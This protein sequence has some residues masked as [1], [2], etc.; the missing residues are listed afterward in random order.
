RTDLALRELDVAQR[1]ARTRPVGDDQLHLFAMPRVEVGDPVSSELS[2][3]A[4]QAPARR[5]QV[6]QQIFADHT[7][8]RDGELLD[9]QALVSRQVNA[10]AV[11]DL[12]GLE[13]ENQFQPA[14][15]PR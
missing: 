3:R 13:V 9:N 6:G 4:V 1:D 5:L 15:G 8:R 14:A 7:T 10:E 12:D 2:G 11:Q